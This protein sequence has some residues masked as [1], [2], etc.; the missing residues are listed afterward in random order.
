M[1][2]LMLMKRRFL[3]TSALVVISLNTNACMTAGPI[4]ATPSACSTLIPDSWREGVEGAP[5]PDGDEVGDWIVFG[6][7]QTGKLDIANG[8]QVDTLAIIQRCEMRDAAAVKRARPK[9]LGVW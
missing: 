6:D 2:A 1:R 9:V 3:Y 4:I 5:L 8:R 7:Q